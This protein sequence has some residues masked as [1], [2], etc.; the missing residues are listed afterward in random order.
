M[1][2]ET[3]LCAVRLG[4]DSGPHEFLEG[5]RGLVSPVYYCLFPWDISVLAARI[6][7]P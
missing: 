6:C 1:T 2:R 4:G 3:P 5:H 7:S